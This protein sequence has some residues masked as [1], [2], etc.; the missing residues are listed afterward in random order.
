MDEK[1][2]RATALLNFVLDSKWPVKK[3]STKK[4]YS[5]WCSDQLKQEIKEKNQK[6]KWAKET[7]N[8]QAMEEYKKLNNKLGN[9]LDRAH[10]M[11]YETYIYKNTDSK[12]VWEYGYEYASRSSAGAPNSLIIN[13]RRIVDQKEKEKERTGSIQENTALLVSCVQ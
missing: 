1:V 13:G 7:G 10:D 9:K 11:Y 4:N 12:Q 2:E 6:F 5:P 8:A 3:I